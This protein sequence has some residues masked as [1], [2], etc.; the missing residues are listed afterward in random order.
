MPNE[1][2]RL[3][4]KFNE[5]D[6]DNIDTVNQIAEDFLE[7]IEWN[8]GYET[9]EI[10]E[11]K[12]FESVIVIHSFFD[13]LK[14]EDGW[15]FIKDIKYLLQQYAINSKE[16]LRYMLDFWNDKLNNKM[17]YFWL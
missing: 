11:S 2:S 1:I 17:N 14:A 16:D 4:R 12:K 10:F 15:E 3:F 5:L 9:I 7:W 8:K 13:I 6:M